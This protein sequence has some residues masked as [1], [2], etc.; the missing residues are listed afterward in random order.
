MEAGWGRSE[1]AVGRGLRRNQS[2]QHLDFSEKLNFCWLLQPICGTLAGYYRD[3]MER[4][5]MQGAQPLGFAIPGLNPRN[6]AYMYI[7]LGYTCISCV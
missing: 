2:C 7:T 1:A 4:G 5:N 6:T 3:R